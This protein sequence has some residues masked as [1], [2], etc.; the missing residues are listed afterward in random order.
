MRNTTI[1][2]G[3]TIELGRFGHGETGKVWFAREIELESGDTMED[4]LHVLHVWADEQE[5]AE[6]QRFARDVETGAN[7]R[8]GRRW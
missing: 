5:T 3:R 7:G 8:K 4:A 2:Y 6:R 1:S